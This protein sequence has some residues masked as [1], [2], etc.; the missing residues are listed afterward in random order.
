MKAKYLMIN[1]LCFALGFLVAAALLQ[2]EAT[3]SD[4]PLEVTK[5]TNMTSA[6]VIEIAPSLVEPVRPIPAEHIDETPSSAHLEN[7]HHSAKMDSQRTEL[8]SIANDIGLDSNVYPDLANYASQ[9]MARVVEQHLLTGLRVAQGDV[10]A[11]FDDIERYLEEVPQ[12]ASQHFFT[13]LMAQSQHKGELFQSFAIHLMTQS[14]DQLEGNTERLYQVQEL[15]VSASQ[16]D[17][18]LVRLSALES[19]AITSPDK[20]RFQQMLNRFSK[21]RSA[22]IQAKITLLNYHMSLA[23]KLNI[24]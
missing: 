9:D 17:S 20:V 2:K 24:D 18:E 12:L 13:D 6:S 19:L 1:V 21:D 8:I 15:I 10:Y 7:S 11:Q 4:T 5:S 14:V 3:L 16:S 22:V 23:S